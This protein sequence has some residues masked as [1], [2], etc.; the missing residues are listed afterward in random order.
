MFHSQIEFLV[1]WGSL[2]GDNIGDA[3]SWATKAKIMRRVP[4]GNFDEALTRL[5]LRL[6][7]VRKSFWCF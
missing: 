2:T 1:R 6:M 3:E 5:T 4:A 7:K